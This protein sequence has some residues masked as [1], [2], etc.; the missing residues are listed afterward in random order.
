LS[1]PERNLGSGISIEVDPRSWDNDIDIDLGSQAVRQR[2]GFRYLK[3]NDDDSVT[4]YMGGRPVSD[5]TDEID[6]TE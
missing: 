4:H 1:D 3:T 2:D 5:E 6:L